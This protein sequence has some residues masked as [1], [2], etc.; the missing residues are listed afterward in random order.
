M[1]KLLII[2]KNELKKLIKN[3]NSIIGK[4][5]EKAGLINE[6]ISQYLSNQL[7]LFLENRNEVSN[8]KLFAKNT[9]KVQ[10]Y[11]EDEEFN[12]EEMEYEGEVMSND[13]YEESNEMEIVEQIIFILFQV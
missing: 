3:N 1:K 10:I 9:N 6:D 7:V 5:V 2:K 11:E 13:E 8:Q 4:R 12:V